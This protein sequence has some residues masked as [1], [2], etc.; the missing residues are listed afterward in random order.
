MTTELQSMCLFVY[1]IAAI[2]GDVERFCGDAV[3][4]DV[5]DMHG[6]W[7]SGARLRHRGHALRLRHHHA[8]SGH[9][10]H[11][12]RTGQDTFFTRSNRVRLSHL[13][14]QSHVAFRSDG[15]RHQVISTGQA[16]F[17]T[18]SVQVK[19]GTRSNR[20]RICH[21]RHQLNKTT[22]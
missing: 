1:N 18:T 14:R 22:S 6:W 12:V 20:I 17:Y 8:T 2:S 4:G 15:H 7:W 13:Q 9:L 16:T 3:D 11:Q 19:L 21:T 5:P 10:R